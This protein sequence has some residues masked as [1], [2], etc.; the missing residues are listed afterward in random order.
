MRDAIAICAVII[1]HRVA[2]G[3]ADTPTFLA[4]HHT[5]LRAVEGRWPKVRFHALREHAGL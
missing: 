5:E 1:K 2:M 3:A 4:Q